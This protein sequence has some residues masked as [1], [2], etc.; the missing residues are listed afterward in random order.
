MIIFVDFVTISA[1]EGVDFAE[2]K[3]YTYVYNAEIPQKYRF[4]D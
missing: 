1:K 3:G 2:Y 4:L